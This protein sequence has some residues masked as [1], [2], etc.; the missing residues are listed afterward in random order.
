MMK[1]R[2]YQ[3]IY[4]C[5]QWTA[6][7]DFLVFLLQPEDTSATAETVARDNRHSRFDNRFGGAIKIAF[8]CALV[9]LFWIGFADLAAIIAAH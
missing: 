7:I 8:W 4:P 5:F 1:K 2:I 9:L 3:A 6:V